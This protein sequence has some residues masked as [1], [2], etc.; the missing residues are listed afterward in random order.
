MTSALEHTPLLKHFQ[1]L[2]FGSLQ[3]H[4]V[5]H[6]LGRLAAIPHGQHLGYYFSVP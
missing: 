3:L 5:R 2:A 6:I 1:A 4:S